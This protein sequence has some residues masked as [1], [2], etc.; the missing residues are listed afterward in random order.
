VKKLP[1]EMSDPELLPTMSREIQVAQKQFQQ[2][3]GEII[4]RNSLDLED[5]ESLNDKLKRDIFF[6]LRV[7]SQLKRMEKEDK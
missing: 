3:V 4:K 7:Q 5:F 1:E 2:N 6:R